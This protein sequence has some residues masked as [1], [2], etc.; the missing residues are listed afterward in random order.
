MQGCCSI[1]LELVECGVTVRGDSQ[2]YHRRREVLVRVRAASVDRGTWKLMTGR[3]NLM[4]IMGFGFR[5]PKALN[6]G[7]SLAG[8]VE[9]V[10]QNVT[11]FNPGAAR[12]RFAT[13][14]S[15]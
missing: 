14:L 2:A 4:R 3:P 5:R 8:I 13:G 15:G 9:A 11:E 10:G 12:K 6:P 7:R 1:T